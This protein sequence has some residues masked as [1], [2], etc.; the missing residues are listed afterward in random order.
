MREAL[1]SGEFLLFD[2]E[3]GSLIPDDIQPAQTQLVESA[4]RAIRLIDELQQI[5]TRVLPEFLK[6]NRLGG[7]TRDVPIDYLVNV[8]MLHDALKDFWLL[9]YAL[10]RH[11][12]RPNVQF[13]MPELSPITP[14]AGQVEAVQREVPTHAEI[15]SWLD[16]M[17][18]MDDQIQDLM[19]QLQQ[20]VDAQG[21]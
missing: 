2:Q 9:S 5:E 18:A 3:T 10:L 19:G 7:P 21:Q 13:E 1:T 17:L 14:F 20:M 8:Y 6:Q 12:E 16:R 11:V 15:D 4:D